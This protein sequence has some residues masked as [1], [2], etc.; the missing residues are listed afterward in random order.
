MACYYLLEM[1]PEVALE[2]LKYWKIN[3]L[4]NSPASLNR[5]LIIINQE[6]TRLN[7]EAIRKNVPTQDKIEFEEL[8]VYVENNIGS[9]YVQLD[10]DKITV[11]KWVKM[12]QSIERKS[13]AIKKQMNG[14]KY[15]TSK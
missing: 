9:N 14:R 11:A 7:I 6:R 8:A 3:L 5:L 4:D 1:R 13:E 2:D 12:I 10:F 15:S